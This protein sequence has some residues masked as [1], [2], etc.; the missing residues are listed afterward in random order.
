MFF[1][2]KKI[3]RKGLLYLQKKLLTGKKA[4]CIIRIVQSVLMERYNVEFE[5][6]EIGAAIKFDSKDNPKRFTLYQ[7]G[8]EVDATKT[9]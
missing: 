9:K 4:K 2:Y 5:A 8:Q 6:S 3:K 7:G 1:A